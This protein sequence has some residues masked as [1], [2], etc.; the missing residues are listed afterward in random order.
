MT[1]GQIKVP[2]NYYL[3]VATDG[4]ATI[5]K[6]DARLRMKASKREEKSRYCDNMGAILRKHAYIYI[7]VGGE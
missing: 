3:A 6:F 2:R 1:C 5:V 4:A 7:R